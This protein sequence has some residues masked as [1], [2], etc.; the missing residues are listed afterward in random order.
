MLDSISTKNQTNAPSN[1][2]TISPARSI[3]GSSNDGHIFT[4]KEFSSMRSLRRLRRLSLIAL[5]FSTAGRLIKLSLLFVP[6]WSLRRR[7]RQFTGRQEAPHQAMS[8]LKA[9]LLVRPM[10]QRRCQSPTYP[11][12]AGS[13]ASMDSTFHRNSR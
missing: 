10:E 13:G 4:P 6:R 5:S 11:T 9:S 7:Q 2:S 3:H 12:S 8:A 1:V